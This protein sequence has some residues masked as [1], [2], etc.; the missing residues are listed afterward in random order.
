MAVISSWL[1][2]L[3]SSIEILRMLQKQLDCVLIL[4]VIEIHSDVFLVLFWVTDWSE[5]FGREGC[6]SWFCMCAKDRVLESSKKFPSKGVFSEE[7]KDVV[8]QFMSV[9]GE[10]WYMCLFV[11]LYLLKIEVKVS[12]LYCFQR[13]SFETAHWLQSSLAGW[14]AGQD[15]LLISLS[16]LPQRWL[17]RCMLPWPTSFMWLVEIW[18]EV[19][20]LG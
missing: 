14:V 2:Q 9:G 20:Q 19:L 6:Y 4:A 3:H 5:N 11:Y 8:I 17:Y 18:I 1:Y 15:A 12:Y 13:P 10:G 16:A 7:M